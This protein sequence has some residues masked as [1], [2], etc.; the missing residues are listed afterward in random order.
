MGYYLHMNQSFTEESWG[1]HF[2]TQLK[3]GFRNDQQ[4]YSA[5]ELGLPTAYAYAAPSV[6]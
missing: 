6:F 5:F 1:Q 2:T 3:S 4:R